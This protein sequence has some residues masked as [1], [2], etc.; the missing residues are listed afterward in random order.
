MAPIVSNNV[1]KRTSAKKPNLTTATVDK[2]SI[3]GLLFPGYN[4][5]GISFTST[6]TMVITLTAGFEAICPRCHKPSKSIHDTRYRLVRDVPPGG[7]SILWLNIGI[8]RV[9]CE[10]GC[11]DTEELTLLS[12]K[13]RYTHRFIAS[14]QQQLR[15]QDISTLAVAR[16]KYI[17]WDAVRAMDEA[18]LTPFFSSDYFD[19]VRY[20]MIDEHAIH[21]G[22]K[23]ATLFVDYET[24]RVIAVVEGRAKA[25]MEPVFKALR[26]SG[27]GKG[28]AAVACD[29]HAGYPS[30]VRKYLPGAEV[31]Y[32][33]FHIYQK[34]TDNVIKEARQRQAQD[35]EQKYG[36][37]S[38]EAKGMR[39]LLRSAEYIL[40]APEETLS[41][42]IKTRLEE[43]LENNR[44]MASLRPVADMLRAVWDAWTREEASCLLNECIEYLTAI[45][46]EF[47]LEKCIAFA[48]MLRSRA[49][50][51]ITACVH[52]INTGP[53]EGINT[54]CKLLKR[55][56]YGYHNFNY[57]RMKI[58]AAFPGVGNHPMDV[59]KTHSA[60][61]KLTVFHTEL[62]RE[63]FAT[64]RAL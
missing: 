28:I 22:H 58:K 31:V 35:A 47:D 23:Y 40:V 46:E 25:D 36:K 56:A 4:I 44:I 64:L 16:D 54:R 61:E 38:K 9:R 63:R 41:P 52:R 8:R 20:L 11:R 45:G 19:G 3:E 29:M 21:K 2:Q 32:D 6:E 13:S 43:M 10:C 1:R 5:N 48:K 24:R 49:N 15:D 7:V 33:G 39:R 51:I 62:G 34:L 18:Q 55:I 26:D 37:K 12:P 53:L 60:V 50:G 57:F 17:G 42:D 27:A 30:L 14:V 59:L